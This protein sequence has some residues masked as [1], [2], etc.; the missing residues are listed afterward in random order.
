M[1]NSLNIKVGY[2]LAIRQIKNASIVTTVLIIFIMML[3]FLNL[4][5]VTGILV[6]LLKSN[7]S[8]TYYSGDVIV[9]NLKEKEYIENSPQIESVIRNQPEVEAV[10]SRYIKAGRLEANYKERTRLTDEVNDVTPL[11][12][13]INVVEEEKV[14][15]ISTRIV[16]GEALTPEDYDKVVIGASLLYTYAPVDSPGFK[17]LRDVGVGSKL[18]LTVGNSVREVTVKGIIKSK[19]DELDMRVFMNDWQLRAMIGRDDNNAS[20]I[21]VRLKPGTDAVA[22]VKGLDAYGFDRYAKILDSESAKPKFLQ[23]IEATFGLMGNIIGSIGLVVASI[24]IFIVIFVNAVTR[25]KFIGILKGIGISS[26]AIEISYV[27]Q[28]AFYAFSGIAIG[29]LIIYGFLRPYIDAHPINFPFSDGILWVPLSG[30]LIR[31]GILTLTT[32]IAGYLPARIIV[33][34]N[35]LDAILG[36]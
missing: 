32:L 9:S 2:F 26:R 8:N 4:V 17:S 22:F 16:E 21:A 12:E 20:E 36:R 3:T 27:F 13:G 5:V 28:A 14:T 6:G 25:R 29:L 33:K 19:V 24:T 1:F 7:A 34:Q 35:T 18:R 30:S 10:A 31:V 15:K 23:D 11:I